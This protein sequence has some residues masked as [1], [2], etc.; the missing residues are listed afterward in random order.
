MPLVKN[1]HC[2]LRSKYKLYVEISFIIALVFIIAAFK[3]SPNVKRVQKYIEPDPEII[4]VELIENT[5]IKK[6]IPPPSP[7]IPIP[8][9]IQDDLLPDVKFESTDL[10]ENTN[11]KL[12]PKYDHKVVEEEPETFIV[13]EKLPEPIGG[14]AGL[15]K[16]LHYNKAA[17]YAEI[18][19]TVV[20]EAVVDKQGKVKEAKIIKSLPGGLD[21]IA[22]KA[23]METKFYPGEQR[24]KPVQTR[25]SIPIKFKLR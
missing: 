16:K 2:D 13:V 23:V 15:Q 1:P 4:K 6:I 19:G 25:F 20:I 10:S 3:F 11:I 24:G 8:T 22:L 18:E 12:P 5:V 21:E 17:L 14:L 9:E 7:Q